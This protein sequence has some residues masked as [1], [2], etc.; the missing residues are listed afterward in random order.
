[1][2]LIE[3]TTSLILA[4]SLLML[5]QSSLAMDKRYEDQSS[6]RSR[7]YGQA[8][9][10]DIPA[11]VIAAMFNE[12]PKAYSRPE[13]KQDDKESILAL[14]KQFQ[15]EDD[16]KRDKERQQRLLEDQQ[17]AQ[18]VAESFKSEEQQKKNLKTVQ[19]LDDEQFALGLE[20]SFRQ[21]IAPAQNIIRYNPILAQQEE[22]L[23]ILIHSCTD[24]INQ[25]EEELARMLVSSFLTRGDLASSIQRQANDIL[26]NLKTL[27]TQQHPVPIIVEIKSI[28]VSVSSSIERVV[29]GELLLEEK[30]MIDLTNLER[31]KVGRSE[32]QFNDILA[33]AAR[34][35]SENMAKL[36]IFAHEVEGKNVDYRVQQVGYRYRTVGENLSYS[37]SNGY[38]FSH[39]HYSVEK[40]VIGLMNSPGH[41]ENILHPEFTQIGIGIH[42]TPDGRKYFTQVFGTPL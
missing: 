34:K 8:I 12:Q 27:K 18:A 39:P 14:A 35:H 23:S 4:L 1:M 21:E 42:I 9:S 28:P 20:Q 16:R 24:A 7:M 22:E 10:D 36:N 15:Q 26:G 17:Y 3:R 19:F 30:T 11:D 31:R 6:E 37:W 5:C 33:Q 13:I 32:L 41:K 40:A 2:K 25:G 29:P 38:P